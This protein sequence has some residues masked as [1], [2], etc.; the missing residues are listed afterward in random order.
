MCRRNR[1]RK[2]GLLFSVL[3][4]TYSI[5]RPVRSAKTC[6]GRDEIAFDDSILQTYLIIVIS[7]IVYLQSTTFSTEL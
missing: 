2:Q 7:K 6:S 4:L 3:L 1:K 5:H